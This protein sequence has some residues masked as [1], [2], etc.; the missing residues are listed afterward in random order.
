MIMLIVFSGFIGGCAL[1]GM[2]D[3]VITIVM[4]M[5][6][7]IEETWVQQLM[8]GLFVLGAAGTIGT[9][10]MVEKKFLQNIENQPGFKK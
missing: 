8:L 6:G 9:L 3:I 7:T 4:S 1:V 10:H 2:I 5:Q